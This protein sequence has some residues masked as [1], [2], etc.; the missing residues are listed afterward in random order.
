MLGNFGVYKKI[1]TGLSDYQ[2]FKVEVG[3][4]LHN[5]GDIQISS[6]H[7]VVLKLEDEVTPQGS[8]NTEDR[9][10]SK[11]M[12]E[13]ALR[14]KQVMV[15]SESLRG[16]GKT[17]AIVNYVIGRKDK[18]LQAIIIVN[19]NHRRELLSTQLYGKSSNLCGSVRV[20]K[21]NL[22]LLNCRVITVKQAI[23]GAIV[24]VDPEIVLDEVPYEDYKV[25]VQMLDSDSYKHD[26]RGFVTKL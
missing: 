13:E 19:S 24:G 7:G 22:D 23:K 3:D 15:G 17:S 6:D 9:H 21:S 20:I 2:G 1:F 14:T 8:S 12:V 26:I 18:S 16:V 4:E 5:I 10:L 11:I 25:I